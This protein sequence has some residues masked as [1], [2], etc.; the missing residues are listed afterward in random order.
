MK[1]K[2]SILSEQSEQPKCPRITNSFLTTPSSLRWVPVLVFRWNPQPRRAK[3]P[4]QSH[5]WELLPPDPTNSHP[6]QRPPG[7]PVG[8]AVPSGPTS[9]SHQY[10][11]CTWN[12]RN[13]QSPIPQPSPLTQGNDAEDIIQDRKGLQSAL[14]WQKQGHELHHAGSS[15][16][17]GGFSELCCGW[18][19]LLAFVSSGGCLSVCGGWGGWVPN[20]TQPQCL[21]AHAWQGFLS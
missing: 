6:L 3:N 18:R 9:W 21:P 19:Q 16:G 5:S 7:G 15:A 1:S 20:P 14:P 8:S 12:D 13:P 17:S 10:T 11:V 4:A 2:N